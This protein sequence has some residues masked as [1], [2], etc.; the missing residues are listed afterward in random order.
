MMLLR[1]K[2][3]R[4]RLGRGLEAVIGILLVAIFAGCATTPKGPA[5]EWVWPLPPEEPRIKF[6]RAYC[7]T[8]DFGKSGKDAFLAAVFGTE[9]DMKMSKP[10]GITSDEDGKMYVTD[11]G[12]DVVWV[13]DEEGKKVSFLGRGRLLTPT[14]IAIGKDGRVFVADSKAQKV[15]VFDKDDQMVM[16]L[17]QKPGELVNPSGLA[18]DPDT[19][20][21]YVANTRLHNIKVYDASNGKFLFD[22]GE[23][24]EKQGQLNFPTNIFIR[25]RKLYV[26]DTGNFRV[27]I[28]DLDGKF[29]STFGKIGDGLGQ[30]ARPK[31]IGV[32]SEGH[33]YAVDSAF[34][35]F[36]IFNEDGQLLLFVGS[37]GT[38][39]GTFW[40]PAGLHVDADDRIYI[41]DQYNHR[42]QIFQYLGKKYEDKLAKEQERTQ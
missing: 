12:Y 7:C 29:L 5:Q 9:G 25:H 24:G 40:L 41:A 13:F 37:K 38:A 42:V 39:P 34:D 26:S 16:A 32:D 6:I 10:Y 21:I 30:F 3:K 18:I 31:G 8:N 27:Q 1:Y 15:F 28:F 36:Q 4:Q 35:N 22:I 14:G 33:I 19:D 20:R 11:T 23:R 2:T 17:G